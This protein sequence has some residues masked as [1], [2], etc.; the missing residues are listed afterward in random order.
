MEK[1][2]YSMIKSNSHNIFPRIQT[3]KKSME[4]Y[5]TRRETLHH[6]KIKKEIFFQQ[7]PKKIAI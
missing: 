5:N 6:T 7:T 4:N 3:F 1:P 2:K